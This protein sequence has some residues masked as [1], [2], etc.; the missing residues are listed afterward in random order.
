MYAFITATIV[1]LS[2][3]LWLNVQYQQK[4]PLQN[5]VNKARLE[6][7]H[8][9]TL[10]DMYMYLCVCVF[11]AYKNHIMYNIDMDKTAW[12]HQVCKCS[13]LV[14]KQHPSIQFVS[15]TVQL[16]CHYVLHYL[17]TEYHFPSLKQTSS[18]PSST[19]GKSD[20]YITMS[21]THCFHWL[22]IWNLTD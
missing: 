22:L 13:Q 5:K 21:L 7:Q 1:R 9:L 14:L 10:Y 4:A 19:L 20:T 6:R 3:S 16:I 8:P 17:E 18:N 12:Q 15:R 11:F 2:K